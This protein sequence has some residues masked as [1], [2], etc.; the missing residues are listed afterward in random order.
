MDNIIFKAITDVGLIRDNNEDSFI[1]QLIW[2]DKHLLCAAID[3]VGG[4]EGGEVAAEIARSSIIQFLNNYP[5]NN[6]QDVISQAVLQAN[7]NIFEQR[8]KG[9][10]PNMSCVVSAAIID[11]VAEKVYI[12]H[13]GDS[14][15][16]LYDKGKLTKLTHDHSL[17]GYREEIGELTE[18]E[19]MNH[20][21]RNIIERCLGESERVFGDNDFVDNAVF[22]IPVCGKL[23]FCSDGLTDM[24]TQAEIIQVLSKGTD[25][26]TKCQSLID[27]AKSHG[28]KDNVTVVLVETNCKTTI[29]KETIISYVND[30]NVFVNEKRDVDDNDKTGAKHH[31]KLTKIGI[32]RSIILIIIAIII[33]FLGGSLIYNNKYPTDHPQVSYTWDNILRWVED[34]VV[35]DTTSYYF[36]S[37]VDTVKVDA[38]EYRQLLYFYVYNI[39]KI[40][41]MIQMNRMLLKKEDSLQLL[42]TTKDSIINDITANRNNLRSPVENIIEK[43]LGDE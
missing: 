43:K 29:T 22:D 35:I 7:N 9:Q 4:Y 26:S 15:I 38:K 2:D 28:G 27:C 39:P 37:D 23:L 30:T 42:I 14:R 5:D 13:V 33:G 31:N 19:A 11:V 12:A 18:V 40:I 6:L 32:W 3:G 10:F 21:R 24:V 36:V 20:P 25:I 41:E 17:V 1:A 16:Y 34:T 8:K